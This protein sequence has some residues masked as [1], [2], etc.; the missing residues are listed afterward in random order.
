M[1]IHK[2]YIEDGETIYAPKVDS[3]QFR[4]GKDRISFQ[5]WLLN[6]PNVRTVDVFWDNGQDSLI[7]PVTPA[8]GLDSVKVI[9][10]NT[11]E[12]AYTFD[13]R[14]TDTYGNHSLKT[15]GFASS[16]GA[17]FESTLANRRISEFVIAGDKG[18]ISWLT[19]VENLVNNEIRYTNSS[20]ETKILKVSSDVF[21]T[22]I[23]DVTANSKFEYRSLFLPETDAI[24]TFS[25]DWVKIFPLVQFD[26]TGWIVTVSDQDVSGINGLLDG[27]ANTYWHSQWGPD[28][29][30]PHWVEIDMLSEKSVTD[31]GIFKH[32]DTKKLSIK[33]STNQ[34]DWTE[35]GSLE[36]PATNNITQTLSFEATKARYIR[37]DLTESHRSPYTSIKE[38]FVYGRMTE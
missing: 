32:S 22:E 13:V 28:I 14:T 34:E 36:F 17:I 29:P 11:E 35:M 2:K 5:A 27:D 31:I 25:V 24:D 6:S 3:L 37:I 10:P 16:Y 38:V 20:N 26:R 30:L 23:E 33:L 21:S 9:I 1:D 12:K 8:V 18:K 4:A 7:I 19:A 15:S